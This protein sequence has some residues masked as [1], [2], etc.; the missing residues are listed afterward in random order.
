MAGVAVSLP[1]GR[2]RRYLIGN[3]LFL[4]RVVLELKIVHG[5]ESCTVE[6]GLKQ[7]WEYMDRCGAD[8]G[9][10]V[11]F[12]RDSEKVWEEKIFKRE[13]TY[14]GMPIIVWGM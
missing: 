9:H 1:K 11:V 7:T 5:L 2:C 8:E 13:R 3:P 6:E 10:L 14:Q 4:W 12:D